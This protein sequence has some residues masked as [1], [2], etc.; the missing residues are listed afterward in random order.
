MPLYEY[1][2]RACQHSLEEIQSFSDEPLTICPQ[3]NQPHLFRVVTGGLG[4]FLSNRTLGAQADTNSDKF[5]EDFKE[6]LAQK[7]E[8]KKVNNIKLQEGASI[9][10][11][12][13]KEKNKPWYKQNQTVTDKA[14]KQATPAQTQN[15]IE[16]GTLS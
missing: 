7:H 5:S 4:F 3:C 13:K 16:K 11:K 8:T 10:P 2:C 14:L 9:A 12:P 6:H 15:Y 1:E